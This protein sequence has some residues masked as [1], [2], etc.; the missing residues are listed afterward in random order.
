MSVFP[1]TLHFRRILLIALS[2]FAACAAAAPLRAQQAPPG[3][4][5]VPSFDSVPVPSTEAS[6]TVNRNFDAQRSIRTP[7]PADINALWSN[8]TGRIVYE[9]GAT[10]TGTWFENKRHGR[11]EL[12]LASGDQY[13]GVFRDNRLN[14]PG[15]Y[16]WASSGMRYVGNFADSKFDGEGIKYDGQGAVMSAGIWGNDEIVAERPVDPSRHAFDRDT[17]GGSG[18]Q[19]VAQTPRGGSGPQPVAQTPRGGAPADNAACTPGPYLE[20]REYADPDLI[21][22]PAGRRARMCFYRST[23]YGVDNIRFFPGGIFYITSLTGSGGFAMSGSVNQTTRGTYGFAEGGRL[24]LRIAY[25]G[26]SVSQSTS[27]AGSTASLDVAG[28]DTAGRRVTLPN[29][30]VVRVRDETRAVAFGAGRAHPGSLTLDGVTWQ[31][32]SDCGDWEGWK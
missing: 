4:V 11:G 25:T 3:M 6:P 31:A 15:T 9:G 24:N 28:S 8:C 32:D 23:K 20:A 17:R 18:P 1:A 30:Q 2:I 10:Y 14:G 12:T 22:R 26:T 19:T 16:V 13:I 21:G 5:G 29:C 7:C 27:G